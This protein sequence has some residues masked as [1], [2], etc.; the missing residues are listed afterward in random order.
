M[1]PNQCLDNCIDVFETVKNFKDLWCKT[2]MAQ[3]KIWDI[4]L[5]YLLVISTTYI[6]EQ[7]LSIVLSKLVKENS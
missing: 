3:N 5:C 7:G 2:E 6:C 4:S 1:V